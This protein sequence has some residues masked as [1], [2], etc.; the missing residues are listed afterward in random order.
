MKKSNN[1]N[2]ISD[3]CG[4][5]AGESDLKGFRVVSHE[6]KSIA[7]AEIEEYAKVPDP[8]RS[9]AFHPEV[10]KT[11]KGYFCVAGFEKIMEAKTSE[12]VDIKVEV[13]E[14][15]SHSEL[16]I[17]LRKLS[18]WIEP[19]NGTPLYASL[20]FSVAKMYELMLASDENMEP[21]I[22]CGVHKGVKFTNDRAADI[23][24]VLIDRWNRDRDTINAYLN[25]S[26][27]LNDATIKKLIEAEAPKVF[28]ETVQIEKSR[29]VKLF[30]K[31]PLSDIT[32]EISKLALGWWKEYKANKGKITFPGQDQ[33]A[34]KKTR[35]SRRT[36]GQSEACAA[37]PSVAAEDGGNPPGSPESHE[38]EEPEHDDMWDLG[39]SI[40]EA[41]N[42]FV[43][44]G[45]HI[46]AGLP[47]SELL[48]ELKGLQHVI[49]E[50]TEEIE[51][52][53]AGL[54]LSLAV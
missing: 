11:E 15:S 28:F 12:A 40:M 52:V 16:D 26:R 7:I 33:A 54:E 32:G 19:L 48:V 44:A 47:D 45:K 31:D 50:I 8:G 42:Q 4:S 17:G 30:E 21:L 25:H 49:E 43:E 38:Q 1:I 10:I 18:G 41:G 51:P 34:S 6:I 2:K 24:K 23:K 46:K 35:A 5:R 20:I 39:V 14:I 29:R 3:S 13:K 53:L 27:Y 37:G 36:E 22:D 9:I